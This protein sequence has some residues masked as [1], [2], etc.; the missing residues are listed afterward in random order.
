MVYGPGIGKATVSVRYTGITLKE[1]A[2]TANPNYLFIYLNISSAT[3]PGEL[4]LI[5]TEGGQNFT[6]KFPLLARTDK[7]GALGFNPSDVLY[8]ITP[9]RFA[10]GDT[11]N[12]NLG[13]VKV[14]RQNPNARHGGDLK[15][16]LDRLDYL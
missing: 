12:D 8:L 16:L 1:V 6:H 13:E 4:P 11:T 3:K 9:D 5:F 14:N 15:G 2:K 7:S 10:N